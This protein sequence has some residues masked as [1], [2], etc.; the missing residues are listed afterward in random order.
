[1]VLLSELKTIGVKGVMLKRL[2]KNPAFDRWKLRLAMIDVLAVDE[3]H[4]V[5]NP[6]AYFVT[7]VAD[8]LEPDGEAFPQRWEE[9]RDYGLISV[10]DEKNWNY[11]P[12]DSEPWHRNGNG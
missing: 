9:L 1:V 6:P 8:Y 3:N 5:E 7:R 10:V 11:V 4:K 2:A 12:I